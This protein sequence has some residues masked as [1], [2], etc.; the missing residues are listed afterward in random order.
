[1]SR[2]TTAALL[3]AIQTAQTG[4]LSD[5]D[6][7]R[8][9]SD[10]N[11]QAA[12]AALLRRHGGMVLGVCR[13][14]LPNLHDAEDAF[15]ATFLILAR[16]ARS[17]NR[18]Q[19]SVANWLYAT[20]RK[21]S[22]NARVAAQRRARR[23]AR[24]AVPE[25][26]PAV[27]GMSGRELLAALDEELGRLPPRYR[28]PLVLCYLEGLTRDE[29]AVRL[30]V[31]AGT[32]KIQLERGRKHLGAALMGRGC[33][34]GAGLLT[35]AAT[36]PAGASQPRLFEDVLAAVAGSPRGAVATLVKGVTVQVAL[37]KSM[38]A[39]LILL[40]VS[41][42]SF[43]TWFL[44]PTGAAP[45]DD[46]A[47][48]AKS[49][50]QQAG[51]ERPAL[52]PMMNVSGRVLD[53]QG[54][55][56][57]GARLM[58]VGR[59]QKSE[60]LG[61]SGADGRFTVKVPKGWE[62]GRFLAACAPGAGLDFAAIAGLNPSRAVE[63]RLVKDNV[64][65]GKIVDT[66]GKPVAGVQVAVTTVGAFNGNS[67]DRFLSA[68]TNRMISIRWPDAD[69]N[70][71][72]AVGAIAAATTDADGRFRLAGTGAERLVRLRASGAGS[73]AA[74]W[75]VV[76][77]PGFNATP[78]N[79][80]ARKQSP[81]NV[82]VSGHLPTPVLYGPE[83]VFVVE[84]GKV[85]R[86][87]VRDA[88]TGKPWPGVEVHCNANS[89]T[90]DAAGRYEIRGVPKDNSYWLEVYT[91]LSA[92]LPGLQVR[93][94]DTDGYTPVAADIAL[95]RFTQTAVITGRLI[96]AATGKGIRGDIHLAALADNAF[97]RT[98]PHR[99]YDHSTSTAEDGTFRIV[100]IPGPVLLMGGV[101]YEWSPKGQAYPSRKYK[102]ATA[103]PRYPQYFPADHPGDYASSSGTFAP[104]QG[105]Y[106]KV[107]QI[108]PGTTVKHG[109]SVEPASTITIKLQDATGRPLVNTFVWE[110][111][112]PSGGF[113]DPIIRSGALADP[114]RAETDSWL[115]QGVAESGQPRRLVFY[116]PGKK[117]FATLTLK[118]DE[119]GPV[120]VRFRPCG[121]VRGTVVDG[122]GKPV[123]GV[124]VN[125]TYLEGNF[126]GVHA[127]VHGAD[128][129]VTDAGGTFIIDEIIPGVEFQLWRRY[130]S[131]R[132][133]HGEALVNSAKVESGRTT[134]LGKL[135]LAE[136]E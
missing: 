49:D 95:T 120:V 9:F 21:V 103:D 116:E 23:E 38:I 15:Q 60:D 121:V 134:D 66:Q 94:P 47:M 91:D 70:L 84:P 118:G 59:T 113:A 110:E 85:I 131:K 100:T 39:A 46:Q 53:P 10:G 18:W 125:L 28:E 122:A 124:N 62:P 99:H 13:R 56:L 92:G 36:S 119:K 32:I 54:R 26:V 133:G 5:A 72:P 89:A 29:A 12:F 127:F 6:L 44:M 114:I 64:I 76:N 87:V 97:A 4:A 115:A 107:L 31:P 40:G 135:K 1:M 42:L 33:A 93:V 130:A 50:A 112:R 35:L 68:W 71:W 106:C 73:A 30:G 102:R 136:G 34:L 81:I 79:E 67:V 48:P 108:E 55:P 43:G 14:V 69:R 57:K 61:T 16:K 104:L 37:K 129:V 19:A 117:L 82:F 128:Q 52:E 8:R 74:Y 90:T 11:D 96:D 27:D 101:D 77:R 111:G 105:S 45:P 123:S 132:S 41:A 65:H 83:P 88:G 98:L 86:G 75:F 3:K 24:A 17:H 126:L 80:T 25:V 2:A 22:H 78:Y 109:I 7:L 20:A 63:L 51:A 58:L